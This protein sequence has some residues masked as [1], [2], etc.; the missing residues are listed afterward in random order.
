MLHRHRCAA[1][2]P[3]PCVGARTHLYLC[4]RAL[5]TRQELGNQEH[6]LLSLKGK[7]AEAEEAR[8][9][10]ETRTH[11]LETALEVKEGLLGQLTR[12]LAAAQEEAAAL[13]AGSE[14]SSEERLELDRAAAA[15]AADQRQ[16]L[17]TAEA[18]HARALQTLEDRLAYEIASR[19]FDRREGQRLAA[20]LKEAQAEIA[21]LTE[22]ARLAEERNHQAAQAGMGLGAP[23][24]QAASRATPHAA[25][26]ARGE[27]HSKKTKK[28]QPDARPNT[29]SLHAAEDAVTKPPVVAPPLP[30]PGTALSG[31]FGL[32]RPSVKSTARGETSAAST[33]KSGLRAPGSKL[34][35]P[36]G[37]PG[38]R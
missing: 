30:T 38:L 32:R 25:S 1:A 6:G 13:R 23:A 20:A 8:R 18:N 2:T 19:E 29:S 16:A 17:A 22:V 33:P 21:R 9:V 28:T 11:A 12:Q 10:A 14:T 24:S 3:P 35:P 15:T 26:N 34:R 27:S 36:P 7:V 4:T 37:K 31:Q 5:R